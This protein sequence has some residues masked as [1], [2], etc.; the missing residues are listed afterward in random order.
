MLELQS[1]F[2]KA[3][4]HTKMG[5]LTTIAMGMAGHTF[6]ISPGI[7]FASKLASRPFRVLHPVN[8]QQS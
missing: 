7:F 2:L 3:M 4:T 1:F 8:R 5:I 6:A